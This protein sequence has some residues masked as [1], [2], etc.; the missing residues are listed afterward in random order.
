[1]LGNDQWRTALEHIGAIETDSPRHPVH[2][3]LAS[4]SCSHV[5]VD[6]WELYSFP[7]LYVHA[8]AE[9]LEKAG[10]SGSQFGLWF[11]G[12]ER[13]CITL[14]FELARQMSGRAAFVT[15]PTFERKA[16]LVA[17]NPLP[18]N[19]IIIVE[20][21]LTTGRSAL[22]AWDTCVKAGFRVKPMILT[23]VNRSGMDSLY[24]PAPSWAS[25][26][27]VPITSVVTLDEPGIEPSSCVKC[28]AGEKPVRR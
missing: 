3:R 17:C 5:Y 9:L 20:D 19:E 24:L 7:H 28:R 10:L 6:L 1:M 26:I 22:V 12:L 11:V 14:A 16:S 18:T 8:C 23:L 27:R 25:A 21:V 13:G 2:V 15:K 4:G